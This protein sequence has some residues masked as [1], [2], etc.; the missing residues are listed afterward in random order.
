[1]EHAPAPPD[2]EIARSGRVAAAHERRC[3][4]AI[5]SRSAG[6]TSITD[7]ARAKS[8]PALNAPPSGINSVALWFMDLIR[9]SL[10]T[11]MNP[12]DVESIIERMTASRSRRVS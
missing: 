9:P 11:K 4:E 7:T 10:P 12:S 3:T 8:P 5:A 6:G 2:L 1:M